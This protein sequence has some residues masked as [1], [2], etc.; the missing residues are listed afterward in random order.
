MLAGIKN[1]G[2]GLHSHNQQHVSIRKQG[3]IHSIGV[4]KNFPNRTSVLQELTPSTKRWNYMKIKIPVQ[5]RKQP[6]EWIVHDWLSWVGR[7]GQN[8]E[9]LLTHGTSTHH[10]S[11]YILLSGHPWG[12]QRCGG[13]THSSSMKEGTSYHGS[14]GC[15]LQMTVVTILRVTGLGSYDF[16]RRSCHCLKQIPEEMINN[17]REGTAEHQWWLLPNTQI[18]GMEFHP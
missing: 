5:Q 16:S 11:Q 4:G 18:Q 15:L 10:L 1:T 9:S 17:L 7:A 14:V 8:T 13:T 12:Y 6:A 3:I 2:A